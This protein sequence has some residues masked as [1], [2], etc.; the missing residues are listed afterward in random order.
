LT[1]ELLI[2]APTLFLGDSQEA[3]ARELTAKISNQ[4]VIAF[5]E[6]YF[7]IPLA[8]LPTSKY[9]HPPGMAGPFILETI[10]DNEA[11]LDRK[12]AFALFG[13]NRAFKPVETFQLQGEAMLVR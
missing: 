11:V 1:L 6:P 7:W 4:A 2:D 9:P 8:P 10:A 13:W 3:T 12:R 5:G